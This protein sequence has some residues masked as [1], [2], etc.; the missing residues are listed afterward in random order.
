[1]TFQANSRQNRPQKGNE[2]QRWTVYDDKGEEIA[3]AG[4]IRIYTPNGKRNFTVNLKDKNS[5]AKKIELFDALSKQKIM[6]KA[7]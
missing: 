2:R 3:Q 1:M 6:E 4:S 5:K 7:I